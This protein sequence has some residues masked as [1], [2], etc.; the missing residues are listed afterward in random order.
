MGQ[1]RHVDTLD[2][3]GWTAHCL[4]LGWWRSDPR[5]GISQ[6]ASRSTDGRTTPGA[7][8]PRSTTPAPAPAAAIRRAEEGSETPALV[9]RPTPSIATREPRRQLKYRPTSGRRFN[10]WPDG[11]RRSTTLLIPCSLS[12]EETSGAGAVQRTAFVPCIPALCRPWV[13]RSGSPPSSSVPLH[14]AHR[15][16]T[17]SRRGWLNWRDREETGGA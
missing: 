4:S 6:T 7:I 16:L 8:R 1:V 10:R 15:G 12:P 14:W 13:S 17:C 5:C 11:A 3:P 9:P 2:H